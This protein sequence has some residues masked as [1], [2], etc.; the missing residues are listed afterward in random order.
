MKQVLVG[1]LLLPIMVVL[2]ISILSSPSTTTSIQLAHAQQSSAIQRYRY[3]HPR[4]FF[5]ISPPVG[6]RLNIQS[7]QF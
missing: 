1:I 7:E 4:T 5:L 6:I 2:F 3:E